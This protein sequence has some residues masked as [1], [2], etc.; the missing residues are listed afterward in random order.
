MRSVAVVVLAVFFGI[1][2]FSVAGCGGGTKERPKPPIT[3]KPLPPT[4][5]PP[6]PAPKPK[7]PSPKPKPKKPAAVYPGSPWNGRDPVF[8]L[9]V[10]SDDR[11]EKGGG[12]CRSVKSSL[13]GSRADAIHIVAIN[14]KTGAGTIINIPRDSWVPIPGYGYDRMNAAFA[15][16]GQALLRRTVEQLTGIPIHYTFV[17]TFCGFVGL[18]NDLGGIVMYVPR[19]I[20]DHTAI[21]WGYHGCPGVQHVKKGWQ[22]LNGCKALFLARDRHS[23]PS[24]DFDRTTNQARILLAGLRRFQELSRT[25]KGFV[26]AIRAVRKDV[27]LSLSWQE[28]FTLGHLARTLKPK[29]IKIAT[30]D[31]WGCRK[32]A[33]SVVCL[34]S[35]NDDRWDR[36]FRDVRSDAVINGK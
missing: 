27:S 11:N 5:K 21:F 29:R 31:G 1:L 3:T 35:N 9:V 7:K 6:E 30:L 20:A 17:T 2:G 10:G 15:F 4:P 34:S 36:L 19:D 25:P 33:A 8:I 13:Q 26:R 12:T 18:I 24:G 14:P 16:G 32:G 28:Y 23:F 22:K